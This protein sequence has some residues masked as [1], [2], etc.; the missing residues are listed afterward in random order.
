MQ[1]KSDNCKQNIAIISLADRSSIGLRRNKGLKDRHFIAAP[2]RP[3]EKYKNQFR[4][5]EGAA[6][7]TKTHRICRDNAGP[8][9]P[10]FLLSPLDATA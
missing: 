8:F 10:H 6:L 2:V 3:W 4:S 5:A 7:K 9:R 1:Q